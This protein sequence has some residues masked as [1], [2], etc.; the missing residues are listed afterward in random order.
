MRC[1]DKNTGIYIA[2]S[3]EDLLS[4]VSVSLEDLKAALSGYIL[5]ASF[6]TKG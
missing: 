4:S 6:S 1:Y 5:S 2:D 3:A